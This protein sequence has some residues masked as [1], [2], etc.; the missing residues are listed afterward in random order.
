MNDELKIS[1]HALKRYLERVKKLDLGNLYAEI[2]TDQFWNAYNVLRCDG[3][4]PSGR[5]YY[6]IIENQVVV[7]ILTSTQMKNRKRKRKQRNKIRN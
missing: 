2:L 5:G 7:T 4:Y 6:V 3:V 1:D